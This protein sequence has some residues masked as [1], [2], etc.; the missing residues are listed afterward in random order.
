M[1]SWLITN[2]EKYTSDNDMFTCVIDGRKQILNEPKVLIDGYVLSRE[3]SSFKL[4]LS[5]LE[6]SLYQLYSLKGEKFIDEIKGNFVIII[7]EKDKFSIYNDHIGINKYFYWSEGNEFIISND[8]AEIVKSVKV[9]LDYNHIA[10]HSIMHHFIA[11]QTLFNNIYCSTYANRVT[12]KSKELTF[13][14]YW[15]FS[16][17]LNLSK[18]SII[19]KKVS[20]DFLR[21]TQSYLDFFKPKQ[22]SMSLTGGMDSRVILS[23]LLNLNTKPNTFTFGN[24]ES[25]DVKIAE[26]IAKKFGLKHDNYFAEQ[27]SQTYDNLV[28]E[29]IMTGNSITHLHRAHRLD[30]IKK[31]KITNPTNDLLFIGHMGGEGIRGLGY[32]NYFASQVFENVNERKGTIKEEIETLL[33]GYFHNINTVDYDKVSDFLKG[34]NYF[35]NSKQINKFY[36]LY[37]HVASIHHA[38]DINIYARYIDKVIPIY[39]DIDYLNLLYSST[40]SMFS[41]QSRRDNPKL[42]CNLINIQLSA[43][44]TIKFSNNFTPNEFLVSPYFAGI[45]KF[46]RDKTSTKTKTNYDYGDWY[47]KYIG[48]QLENLNDETKMIYD[49]ITVSRKLQENKHENNEGYWHKYSNLVLFNKM[50]NYYREINGKV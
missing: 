7:I 35:K 38:Q 27:N 40:F 11:G 42:Y 9:E 34:Q 2:H 24:A 47:Q 3:N 41:K 12:Y 19:Y 45:C 1:K 14:R 48:S 17:L 23:A 31:D 37:E 18:Q 10:I 30:A 28:N 6:E 15:K 44:S 29:I 4:S 33:K 20:D 5:D 39:L 16:E 36:F 25:K 50:I 43:L 32:N 21:I 26:N 49:T 22:V 8:F 13:G 46:I